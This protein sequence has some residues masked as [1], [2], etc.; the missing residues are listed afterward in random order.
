MIT[1]QIITVRHKKLLDQTLIMSSTTVSSKIIINKIRTLTLE[2]KLTFLS[3][4]IKLLERKIIKKVLKL[5]SMLIIFQVQIR[6][7][8][9]LMPLKMINQWKLIQKM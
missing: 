3:T 4:I 7:D 8:L 9:I 2:S 5:R 1:V 6:M